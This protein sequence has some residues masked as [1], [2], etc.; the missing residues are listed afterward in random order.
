MRVCS[1][2]TFQ[3]LCRVSKA[4]GIALEYKLFTAR[5]GDTERLRKYYMIIYDRFKAMQAFEPQEKVFGNHEIMQV[6]QY[7]PPDIR[8]KFE[9][10][11]LTDLQNL[12]EKVLRKT[13]NV[14]QNMRDD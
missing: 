6:L 1:E 3:D 14:E 5:E 13:G 12:E 9:H 2:M 10:I 8:E 11:I 7:F 4:L